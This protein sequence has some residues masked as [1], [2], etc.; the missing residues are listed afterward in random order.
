M[1]WDVIVEE[2]C[3]FQDSKYAW[4]LYMQMLHK[5]LICLNMAE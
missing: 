5:D 1:G 4:G 2:L 3:I